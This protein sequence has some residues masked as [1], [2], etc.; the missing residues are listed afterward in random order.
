MV[1]PGLLVQKVTPVQQEHKDQMEKMDLLVQ[2][3]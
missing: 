1:Q 3:V 2:P